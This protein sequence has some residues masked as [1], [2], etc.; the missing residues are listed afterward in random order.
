MD[1]LSVESAD[2]VQFD[3]R[4]PGCDAA[5]R[6]VRGC[7][8]PLDATVGGGENSGNMDLEGGPLKNTSWNA[9]ME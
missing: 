5:L 1:F 7:S 2:N 9:G 6:S 4:A 3:W 8:M